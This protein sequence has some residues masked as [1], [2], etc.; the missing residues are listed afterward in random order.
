MLSTMEIQYD[1]SKAELNARKHG[2]SFD[3]ATSVL[4]DPMG[5]SF[6]DNDSENEHRWVLLG[7]SSK[8]RLLV[9]VYIFRDDEI[10]RLISARKATRKEVKQYA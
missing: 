2:V 10:I 3:E 1:P 4:F 8:D 9:V 5:L 6:E 7:M